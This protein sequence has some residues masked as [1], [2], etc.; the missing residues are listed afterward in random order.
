MY[1]YFMFQVDAISVLFMLISSQVD[2]MHIG[3]FRA[4]EVD[5]IWADFMQIK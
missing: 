3:R 2:F 5:A 4:Y 1:V